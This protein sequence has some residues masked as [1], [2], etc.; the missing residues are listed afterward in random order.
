MAANANDLMTAFTQE[1]RELSE[2]P[3]KVL[4]DQQ[5][6]HAYAWSS[7]FRNDTLGH[8]HLDRYERRVSAVDAGSGSAAVGW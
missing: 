8:S 5:K 3:R 2:L 4:V 1:W 7:S 6:S